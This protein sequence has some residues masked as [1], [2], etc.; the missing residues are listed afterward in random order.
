MLCLSVGVFVSVLH[1]KI[2]YHPIINKLASTTL[3]IYLLHDGVLASWLW[4]SLFR[5][6]ERQDSP[7][8][9]FYILGAAAV[10]LIVGAAVDMTRQTLEKYTLGRLLERLVCL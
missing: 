6:A 5:C 3:G 4:R 1:I 9:I 2:S 10:V 8:L 7:Y